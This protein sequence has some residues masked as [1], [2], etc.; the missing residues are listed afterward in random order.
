MSRSATPSPAVSVSAEVRRAVE[1]GEPV[2]ALESTFFTH[3]LPRPRNLRTARE[4]EEHL[5]DAGVVPAT[6]GIVGGVPT[7]GLSDAEI[8]RLA[9]EK[10]VAKISTRDLPVAAA[11]GLDGGTTVAA[12]S[13]LAH[14]AGITVFATGGLGGVHHGARTSFDESADLV[15]LA[16]TPVVVVSAGVKSILDIAATL[17][18]LETLNIPVV[19]YRTRHYPG[20]YVADSGH[21]IEHAVESPE[22]A[23]AMVAAHRALRL[24]SAL[25]VANPVPVGEQLDPVW[26]QQ[27]LDE[28]WAAAEA[29]KV[30]GKDTTPFLLDYIQRAS[31]GKSLE[32]NIAVYRNNITVGAAIARAIATGDRR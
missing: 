29:E 11:K 17:E 3:G 16:T 12:T 18:R 13:H 14:L 20:F 21:E 5:R 7:V 1:A 28:A 15:A 19:G 2:V 24:R 30:S 26:H 27:L 32:V 8:E 23:A 22:E 4:A 10:S 25:L 9:T 6:I 31:G